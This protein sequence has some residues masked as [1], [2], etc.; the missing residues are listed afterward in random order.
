MHTV[1]L[2]LRW[3]TATDRCAGD[4][5]VGASLQASDSDSVPSAEIGHELAL[6][7]ERH[8]RSGGCVVG[9]PFRHAIVVRVS[10]P[11]EG[12]EP[13]LFAGGVFAAIVSLDNVGIS[14]FLQGSDFRVLPV[15]LYAYAAY[16]NDPLS[17][18]VSVLLILVSIGGVALM[19]RFFGLEKLLS[20]R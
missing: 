12:D 11:G 14:L 18:A 19:Q 5:C 6:G 1:D 10:G 16:N 2:E 8:R 3:D 17:A 13:G 7:V 20:T 15:E 9:G 4:R